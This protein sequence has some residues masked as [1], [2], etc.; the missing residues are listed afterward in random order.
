MNRIGLPGGC[1][2]LE[3]NRVPHGWPGFGAVYVG[4]KDI[5]EFT[6]GTRMRAEG[7]LRCLVAEHRGH[8][9]R[10]PTRSQDRSKSGI[11]QR[12]TLNHQARDEVGFLWRRLEVRTAVPCA[13]YPDYC[14]NVERV[15]EQITVIPQRITNGNSGFVVGRRR[16]VGE[17]PSADR[18]L[19]GQ[20]VEWLF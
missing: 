8:G 12:G 11:D 9:H 2:G 7:N 14:G 20:R 17:S 19:Y 3:E 4:K 16:F 15:N 6:G 18:E 10:H 1:L 13:G 5:T